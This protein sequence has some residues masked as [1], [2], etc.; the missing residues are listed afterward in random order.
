MKCALCKNTEDLALSHIIPSF[1]TKWIKSTSATG[2]LR[3]AEN[4]N[5]RV[6][7]SK[8]HRLLCYDCEK[9]LNEFETSFANTVFHPYVS[10]EL[11]NYGIAKGNIPFFTHD[12]WMIKFII[13]LQW[14]I[15]IT[16]KEIQSEGFTEEYKTILDDVLEEWRQFLLGEANSFR[17]CDTHLIFLQNLSAAKGNFP[18]DLNDKINFY[19]LRAIDGT[20]IFSKSSLGIFSKIGPIAFYTFMLPSR[21]KSAND[22]RIRFR[23]K[24]IT[25]Q[26]I[27]NQKLVRFL[28][29]DRPNEVMPLMKFSNKQQ[30]NIANSYDKDIDKAFNSLTV[31]AFEADLFLKSKTKNSH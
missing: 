4:I 8:K 13:S 17:Y 10:D 30:N 24:L 3:F 5:L 29:I 26:K 16:S 27:K 19:L 31:R 1:V 11:D 23:G 20:I 21:L 12:I 25:A 14:R 18:P 22:T 7:D 9:I 2:Y 28:F 6:Q 15:A